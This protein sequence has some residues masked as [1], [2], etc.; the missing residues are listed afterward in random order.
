MIGEAMKVDR[1]LLPGKEVGIFF[2][3]MRVGMKG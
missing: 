3:H 1:S 2:Q